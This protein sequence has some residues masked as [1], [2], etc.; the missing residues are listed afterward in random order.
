MKQLHRNRKLVLGIALYNRGFA[1]ALIHH[2]KLINWG[3]AS[4]NGKGDKNQ[5]AINRL[6]RLISQW[7]PDMV[8]FEDALAADSHR[9]PR[10]RK[11]MKRMVTLSLNRGLKAKCVRRER[12]ATIVTGN[13]KGT[14]Y[15]LAENILK[16][17]PNELGSWLP[18][19][20]KA[21]MVEN[22]KLRVFDA[23]AL[24][25]SAKG[26]KPNCRDFNFI[27]D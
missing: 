1:F 25:W 2:A 13:N 15:E 5:W 14:K 10:V 11:L 7:N 19:K 8:V 18:P 4:L 16:Q 20:R 9:S 17:F 3:L 12:L 27:S 21:W 22:P 26:V 23:V 24:A 6:E